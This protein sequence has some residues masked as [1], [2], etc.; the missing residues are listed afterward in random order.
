MRF[1]CE[2]LCFIIPT[3][4]GQPFQWTIETQKYQKLRQSFHK[5]AGAIMNVGEE[6]H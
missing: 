3:L 1:L 4:Q 6:T 2:L 5:L